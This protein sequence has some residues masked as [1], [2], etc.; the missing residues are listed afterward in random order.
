MAEPKQNYI[1]AKASVDEL[2]LSL[3]LD[4]KYELLKMLR[5]DINECIKAVEAEKQ[6]APP[7]TKL[8]KIT[9]YA[10]VDL[11]TGRLLGKVADGVFTPV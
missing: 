9:R 5:A 8:N 1:D 7:V 6:S 3:D 2:C 4:L 10:V 11:V